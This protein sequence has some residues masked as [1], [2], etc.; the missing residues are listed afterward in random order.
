MKPLNPIAHWPLG[1]VLLLAL[2]A[3]AALPL[4]FAPYG[5]WP[6]AILSPALL[7][8]ALSQRRPLQ[9]FWLGLAYGFGLWCV[10]AFWLY[11]S[12]HE[13][14]NT[15]APIALLMIAFVGVAM[16]LFN[17]VQAYLYRQ[18]SPETPLT[19]APFWVITE[20]CKT[21][22][23]TGFPWLFVGYG[24]TE[25]GLD[26]Y[27]PLAGVFAVSF[28]VV[29]LGAA[30]VQ[31]LRGQRFWLLPMLLLV[32][33]GLG[34][35]RV[36]WTQ[37]KN[38]APLS[39]SLVQGNIPQDL[40]WLTEYRQKTLQIYAELSASEWGRDLVVWPEAAI[41]TFQL[42]AP[43]FI[44]NM[45][46]TAQKH[47]SAWVTGIPW[48]AIEEYQRGVDPYPPFYNS[49]MARGADSHG[50]YKK[51]RLVPFGEYIPLQG[52]LE[53]VL[54]NLKRNMDVA[55]FSAG[56]N[57]QK[58]LNIKGNALGAAICYEVAYPNITRRNAIDSDFM[59]T[60]SND[61]WFK[62]SDGPLQHLQMVQMRAK[63]TGRWFI[64]STNTGVTAF[65]DQRG[66]IVSRTKQFKT[67]VL[68]GNLP[69]MQGNTPYMLW[70]D[71][72]ILIL[73]GALLLLGLRFRQKKPTLPEGS[74]LARY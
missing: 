65:I 55:S 58:P 2:L 42:D 27:A 1:T 38:S 39:V 31:V 24:F 34:L 44:K 33:V 21:W 26:G 45:D 63:E 60:L 15:P 69:A 67:T 36:A 47:A 54:P 12:I 74:L 37:A 52:A 3:G 11:T 62:S 7:Y 17:A 28:V 51:Q 40:K 5:C 8:W 46:E 48:Q 49:I 19:F 72:P 35:D 9:A 29:M 20:W 56:S 41:P 6:V 18:L 71:W 61:A 50:L 14:G 59:V 22:V 43:N 64:R 25:R 10:G 73:S 68:R 32:G 30:L 13:Y 23:F 53:W 4:A 66:H 70:G 57:Q 16:G